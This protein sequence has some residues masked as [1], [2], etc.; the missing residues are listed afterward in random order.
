MWFKENNTKNRK[1][2][3][4]NLSN[5]DLKFLDD[6]VDQLTPLDLSNNQLKS[7]RNYKFSFINIK[8]K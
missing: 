5:N 1:I 4:F 7:V 8:R 3:K 6:G 2:S